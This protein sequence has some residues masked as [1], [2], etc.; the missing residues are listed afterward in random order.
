[1]ERIIYLTVAILVTSLFAS[2]AHAEWDNGSSA[3]TRS[4][5]KMRQSCSRALMK[6]TK[7]IGPRWPA[8]LIFPIP[9]KSLAVVMRPG[10]YDIK[11]W[12]V[13]ELKEARGVR[14]VNCCR[15]IS[16]TLIR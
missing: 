5:Y 11:T 13:A 6:F 7:N 2:S 9:E 3:C 4:A 15:K 16:T 12:K 14:H 10:Q 8:A 1:M